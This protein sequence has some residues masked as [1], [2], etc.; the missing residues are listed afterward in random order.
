MGEVW[1]ARSQDGASV[2]VKVLREGLSDDPELVSMFLR[3]RVILTRLNHPN[4]VRVRDLVAEGSTLAIVMDLVSG[5]NLRQ[6]L[7]PTGT[8]LPLAAGQVMVHVLQG[9][10]VAHGQGVVHRDIKPENVLVAEREPLMARLTDFG[11][12]KL[13]DADPHS[14]MTGAIGTPDYMPPEIVSGSPAAPPADV[15]AAG[16]VLYELLCGVTPFAGGGTFAVLRRAAEQSPG[17][18]KGLPN[19]VWQ[20]LTWMM[21]KFPDDRPNST[22]AGAALETLLPLLNDVPQLPRLQQPPPPEPVEMAATTVRA[23]R[24]VIPTRNDESTRS[25]P[26]GF[27]DEGATG[28]GERRTIG[29]AMLIAVA[30]ALVLLTFLIGAGIAGLTAARGA[31]PRNDGTALVAPTISVGEH[32]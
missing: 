3:E 7:R 12:A 28:D 13:C 18:P 16:V 24:V 8:L 19:D 6:L 21:E 20:L 5:P 22:E 14:R 32:S 15:Y 4:I 31:R 1:R 29:V 10:A 2:A 30:A 26:L 25:A 27:K 17:R 23:E 11:I 9:L